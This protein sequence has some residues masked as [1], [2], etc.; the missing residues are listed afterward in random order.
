MADS[1]IHN[2]TLR[3]FIKTFSL[4]LPLPPVLNRSNVPY[5]SDI[6]S[7]YKVKVNGSVALGA[8]LQAAGAAA[9]ALACRA[10]VAPDAAALRADRTQWRGAARRGRG[11]G[12]AMGAT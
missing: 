12:A 6:L 5:T 2:N 10:A 1:L 11:P 9:G 8:M 3:W 7:G 4:P